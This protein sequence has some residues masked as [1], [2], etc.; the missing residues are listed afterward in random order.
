VIDGR[1]FQADV[2]VCSK[3]EDFLLGSDWREQ[4]GTQWDFA[5]GTVTLGDKCDWAIEPQGLGPNVMTAVP[6]LAIP[7]LS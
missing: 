2:S 3:V 5:S 7:K 1:A 4:Q 6:C